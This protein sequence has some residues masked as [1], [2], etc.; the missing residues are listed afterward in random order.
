MTNLNI[1]TVTDF[2][3]YAPE[4]DISAYSGATISG[5]ISQASQIASDILQYTPLA[6]VI[7][8]EI[9]EGRITTEGDL[10]I[11]PAK[12]PVQSV[13]A[14][15]LV[16]GTTDVTLTIL[17]GEGNPRYNIDWQKR[18]IRYPNYEFSTQTAGLLTNLWSL[19]GRQFYYKLDYRGGFEVSELPASITHAVV[20]IVRDI[21][22]Q[23]SNPTGADSI[24]QGGISFSYSSGGTGDSAYMKEAKK[25]LGDY[26]RI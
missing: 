12:V 9:G 19:R 16:K 14:I 1:I 7:I 25:I 5:M 10:I 15:H 2:Q 17:D 24:S 3:N 26:R 13:S 20:L 11:F 8:G 4:V 22:S 18:H 6:E 21:I 23:R